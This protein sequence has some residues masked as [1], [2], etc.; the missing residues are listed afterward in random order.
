[1]GRGMAGFGG[2]GAG[3]AGMGGGMGGMGGGFAGG[4]SAARSTPS[5]TQERLDLAE[6]DSG[7]DRREFALKGALISSTGKDAIDLAQRL[8]ARKAGDRAERAQLVRTVAGH[9]FRKVGED[10][11]D[12]RFKPSTPILHLRVLGKAYFRLLAAHP[13]I[14]PILA[15]GSRV[16]WVSPSGTV[17]LIDRQGPDDV[18]DATLERLFRNAR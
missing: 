5:D 10:W 15:L 12:Q 13:A 2:M 11:V 6:A 4:R 1:M 17:L 9:R 18:P 7:V 14:Q 16:T 3:M 8:A